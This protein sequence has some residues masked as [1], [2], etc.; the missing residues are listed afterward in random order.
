[1]ALQQAAHRQRDRRAGHADPPAQ[2][3]AEHQEGADPSRLRHP[4]RRAS[5][6]TGS[7]SARRSAGSRAAGALRGKADVRSGRALVELAARIDNGGDRIA[8][9]ARRRARPQQVRPR[10]AR[11][12]AGQWPGS[13]DG[14]HAA[15]RSTCRSAATGSW[16]RWRGRARARPVG[17]ADRAA[18][19]RRR[20]RAATGSQ[21]KWAP[22]QF[23]T[24][25]LQR[26]TAPVV[27]DPRRRDAQGPD[28]RRPADRSARRS[29]ARSRRGA[30]DLADNR[31]RGMR[32]GI[33]LLKPPAL[34]PNMTGKSVRMVWTLD[35]PFA[36]ADYSYRLTSPHVQFD[37]TGFDRLARR[38]PRAARARGRCACRS[39]SRRGRS[40]ASATS[41]GR[42][43]PIRR[44]EGWLTITPKLVR[45]EDL[46]LTS[47]KWNGKLSLLIDL[48]TGRFEVL[49]S[50][51][52]QRYLIPG[53][54]IV[55][56]ITDL[57]VVPGP[58]RQGLARRRHR[59]GLGAPARQQLLPRPDRR[60]AV[61]RRRTSSAAMTASS[62]SPICSSIR[63][64]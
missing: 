41:P 44:I 20:Q 34:F 19:A 23:L 24:G 48:V 14:R 52:M 10:R 18:C 13:G 40:P 37:D 36:T 56:V 32:L 22:A 3:Q 45:G 30:L 12:R 60:A 31:Y 47:A 11:D 2:A 7:T 4:Y 42:C 9:Q 17:P 61:A 25:K 50:G 26:L 33:D 63:P 53:L 8:L 46:K 35:G 57:K 58:E 64:S 6:S 29:F 39:G 55:D 62:I 51:A 5:R 15:A 27:D 21:G 49:L 16:T 54:G 59:Q 38:G 43:S 1:M 28:P